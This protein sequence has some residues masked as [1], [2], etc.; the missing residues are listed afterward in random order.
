MIQKNAKIIE[1]NRKR[2]IT[3]FRKKGEGKK[4]CPDTK[5][6]SQFYDTFEN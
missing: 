6:L 1:I 4:K 2:K 5:Y 3:D